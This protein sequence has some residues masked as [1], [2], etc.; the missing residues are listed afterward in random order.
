M[1][2]DPV[3]DL[4]RKIF[5]GKEFPDYGERD[6]RSAPYPK[7][8]PSAFIRPLFFNWPVYAE[9][10]ETKSNISCKSYLYP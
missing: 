4:F 9:T 7:I 8:T 3:G 5:S 1:K 2:Q 10:G 6:G